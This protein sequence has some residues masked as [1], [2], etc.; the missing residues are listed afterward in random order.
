M[1]T[2]LKSTMMSES[3][4][5][6]IQNWSRGQV[7][8]IPIYDGKRD[9]FSNA[10]FHEKCDGIGHTVLVI[11][12]SNGRVFGGYTPLK[13]DSSG[14]YKADA[15][16]SS[17]LFAF[18]RQSGIKY[19][20]TNVHKTIFCGSE[21]G[22]TFGENHHIYVNLDNLSRSYS[23]GNKCGD[24]PTLTQNEFLAGSKTGWEIFNICIFFIKGAD[25]RRVKETVAE[26]DMFLPDLEQKMEEPVLPPTSTKLAPQESP[27]TSIKLAPMFPPPLKLEEYRKLL[28]DF[29]SK[30]VAVAK[31]VIVGGLGSGKSTLVNQIVQTLLNS[32]IRLA[33]VKSVTDVCAGQEK[34]YHLHDMFG[35]NFDL[36]ESGLG[37]GNAVTTAHAVI[38]LVP[39]DIDVYADPHKYYEKVRLL[40][41]KCRSRDIDFLV[42]MT[43]VDLID[44]EVAKCPEKLWESEVI[45]RDRHQ[46][47]FRLGI[48]A[49][50]VFPFRGVVGELNFFSDSI[51]INAG[52]IMSHAFDVAES[53]FYRGFNTFCSSI[54][55][56][57]TP[58]A[59]KALF[60]VHLQKGV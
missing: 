46:V 51:C 45:N 19:P 47:A 3:Q 33:S 18:C 37:S 17:F 53:T 57:M 44:E 52:L 11:S 40:I 56:E 26:K 8:S 14:R 54:T 28:H 25:P 10:I 29:K 12:L 22:P 43:K 35:C 36:V 4:I 32:P 9:G 30:F 6:Q 27:P 24:F 16:V 60:Q 55:K 59:K 5:E 7:H 42:V 48:D 13:W 49:K 15:S 23:I 1:E 39:V 50:D 20:Q 34:I 2:I 21:Y 41:E 38:I 58:E 31:I